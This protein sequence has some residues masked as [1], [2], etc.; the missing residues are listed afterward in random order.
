MTS[1]EVGIGDGKGL[2][3]GVWKGLK[4]RVW[5]CSDE[6]MGSA[7][8]TWYIFLEGDKMLIEWTWEE[9]EVSVIKMHIIKFSNNQ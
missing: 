3:M 8:S 4:E 9:W 1:G 2:R 5:P 7:V 6:Y